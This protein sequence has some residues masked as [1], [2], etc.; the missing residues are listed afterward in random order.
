VD[1]QANEALNMDELEDLFVDIELKLM[2]MKD[3]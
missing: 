3:D 2:N 1:K